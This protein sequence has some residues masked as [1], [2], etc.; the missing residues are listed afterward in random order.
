MIDYNTLLTLLR[1]LAADTPKQD[2][3][4]GCGYEHNCDTEG[5]AILRDALATMEQLYKDVY[6][7][8]F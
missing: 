2:G 8:K 7:N 3:C 1:E 4:A 5:C 6:S